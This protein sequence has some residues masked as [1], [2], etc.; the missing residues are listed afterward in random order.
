MSN[1]GV[2]VEYADSVAD[3]VAGRTYRDDG[4][5][6]IPP[7]KPGGSIFMGVFL[8]LLTMVCLGAVAGVIFGVV[9]GLLVGVGYFMRGLR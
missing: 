4:R 9:G 5:R 3:A 6:V 1:E 8:G 7:K 2:I